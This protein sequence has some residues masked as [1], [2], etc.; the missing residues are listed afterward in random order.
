MLF[1]CFTFVAFVVA[2]VAVVGVSI[3]AVIDVAVGA[4]FARVA[5][6]RGDDHSNMAVAAVVVTV[7]FFVVDW[8]GSFACR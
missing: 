4:V 2:S 6:V 8:F 3:V 5:G 1:C 7:L